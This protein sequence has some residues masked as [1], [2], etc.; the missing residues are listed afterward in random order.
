M[1]WL[2]VEKGRN[3]IFP[4]ETSYF[5]FRARPTMEPLPRDDGVL[6]LFPFFRCRGGETQ[7]LRSELPL[8]RISVA[9]LFSPPAPC[10]G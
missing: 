10:P 7:L 9:C 1:V 8:S 6:F 4:R 5:F 2:F 3:V